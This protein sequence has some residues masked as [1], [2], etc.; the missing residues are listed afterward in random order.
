MA[1][2]TTPPIWDFVLA[3]YRQEGVSEAAIALQDSV[4]IDVNMVLFLMWMASQKRAL[5]A[6]AV[7]SVSEKSHP[8][9]R[10]VVVPIREIRRMLK[11]DAPLVE[12]ETALAYRKKVQALE[13]EGEQ[14][15]LTAMAAM[16]QTLPGTTAASPDAA[17]RANLQAFA[18]AMAVKVPQASVDTFVRAL[19]GAA[20]GG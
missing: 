3:F 6:A 12:T 4:G 17:A 2:E 14:L 20:H 15:Q 19:Q 10:H 13:L 16:A 7:K 18:E 8:W 9:Q 11:T 1:A 5:D